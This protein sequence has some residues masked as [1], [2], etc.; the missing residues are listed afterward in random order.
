MQGFVANVSTSANVP[1]LASFQR[2]AASQAGNAGF[3]MENEKKL[4]WIRICNG[5]WGTI[6][7]V[8]EDEEDAPL[9]TRQRAVTKNESQCVAFE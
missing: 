2:R 8:D 4:I 6:I 1:G 5:S 9:L 7:V 3:R